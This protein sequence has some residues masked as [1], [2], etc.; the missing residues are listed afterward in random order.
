MKA[1]RV[2]VPDDNMTLYYTERVR[3]FN[4]YLTIVMDPHC[5][6]YLMTLIIPLSLPEYCVSASFGSTTLGS[7]SKSGL[8]Y[9]LA[10]VRLFT[11]ALR[12]KGPLYFEEGRYR[13]STHSDPQTAVSGQ[14]VG[15]SSHITLN[16]L[17]D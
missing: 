17:G 9:S 3:L 1:A 14:V 2:L 7:C 6:C 16:Y 12:V 15:Q 11:F 10:C 13:S 5:I 8:S 4:I